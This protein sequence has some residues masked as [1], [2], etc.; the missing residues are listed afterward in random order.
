[1]SS[2][3]TRLVGQLRLL[4]PGLLFAGSAIGVSHIYQSTRAG[5]QYGY[6]LVGVVLLANLLKY[7][8]F[9]FGPR[10]ALATGESLLAGYLRLGR[11]VL[12]LFLLVTI[13]TIFTIQAA[14]TGV[15]V[16]IMQHA[17]GWQGPAWVYAAG[18]LALCATILLAGRY[19]TLDTTVKAVIIVLALSTL[20]A[21]GVAFGRP[22]AEH[23]V[24]VQNFRISDPMALAFFIGLVGWMPAPID[25]SVWHSTWALEKRRMN[26]GFGFRQAMLDFRVGYIGTAL[27]AVV[28]LALG[29][30]MLHGQMSEFPASAGAFG[31]LL[32]DLY[33]YTLGGGAGIVIALAAFATMF[34]T[35]LTVLDAIPR[36]MTQTVLLLSQPSDQA[37]VQPDDHT[38][39]A[40]TWY[41]VFLVL[42]ILGA[43]SLIG[44]FSD[45]LRSLVEVATIL[46]F[47]TAP[48]FAI[49]NHTL[50]F[51]RHTP[52]EH[53]P[54][55]LMRL[56]SY[57]G[58]AFLLAFGGWFLLA[59]FGVL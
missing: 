56:A 48:F 9:E 43:L 11:W 18:L 50:I 20:V 30:R 26:P 39:G 34:S 38:A 33:R 57:L 32:I 17:I 55:W 36:V 46:S 58:M 28:F 37:P 40:R 45:D 14:V 23:S 22:A 8:F 12:G 59:R 27:L 54:G 1:M 31:A 44:W 41:T 52:A 51:G 19:R 7:P 13:L 16:A 2:L 10:Y 25:L 42:L 21:L 53:Q 24:A 29:A 35:T 15:T 47:G 6:A 5:A 49:A 4:G 3:Y